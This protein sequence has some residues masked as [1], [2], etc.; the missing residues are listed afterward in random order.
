MYF[1][2][3]FGVHLF[4]PRIEVPDPEV[5]DDKRM[6]VT[7]GATSFCE[8]SASASDTAACAKILHPCCD[9]V[10]SPLAIS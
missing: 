9:S 8:L 2:K 5:T 7:N 3:V 1:E 4:P 6:R 10:A